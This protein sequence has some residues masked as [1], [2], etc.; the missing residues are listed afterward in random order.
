MQDVNI[1]IEAA[2]RSTAASVA[3]TLEQTSGAT[4]TK[5]DNISTLLQQLQDQVTAAPDSQ[6]Q[7]LSAP[8]T[9][10]SVEKSEDSFMTPSLAQSLARLAGLQSRAQH[11]IHD[12]EAEAIIDDLEVLLNEL[13]DKTIPSKKRKTDSDPDTTVT[14]RDLKRVRRLVAAASAVDVNQGRKCRAMSKASDVAL[15]SQQPSDSG[16]CQMVKS[17]KRAR[18]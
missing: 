4:T 14:Y 18:P 17:S 13:M 15:I 5:L 6:A 7:N 16:T 3:H 12:D 9:K 11:T 2:V 1:S 8:A 10:V